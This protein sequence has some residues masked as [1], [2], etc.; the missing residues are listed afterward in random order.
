MKNIEESTIK[1]LI[2]VLNNFLY[3]PHCET[4]I[5]E[6]KHTREGFCKTCEDHYF[7]GQDVLSEL[8]VM[9]LTK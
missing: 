1:E 6:G 7:A 8:M 4:M 9:E 5:S 2:N 3:N